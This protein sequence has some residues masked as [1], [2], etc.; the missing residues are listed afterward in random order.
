M[1]QGVVRRFGHIKRIEEKRLKDLTATNQSRFT[2][3]LS[4]V[5]VFTLSSEKSKHGITE[6]LSDMMSKPSTE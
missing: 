4:N 5:T 3:K 2:S 1:D 6:E